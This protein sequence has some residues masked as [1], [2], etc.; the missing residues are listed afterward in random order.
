M[1]NHE[2]REQ[3]VWDRVCASGGQRPDLTVLHPRPA[4]KSS[5]RSALTPMLQ[6]LTLLRLLAR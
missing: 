3:A 1:R 2:L 6:T 4:P 5:R